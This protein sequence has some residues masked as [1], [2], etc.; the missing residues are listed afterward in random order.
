MWP[1]SGGGHAVWRRAVAPSGPCVTR[2]NSS[3]WSRTRA[4]SRSNAA[5]AAVRASWRS[6]RTRSGSSPLAAG[7]SPVSTQPQVRF[8]HRSRFQGERWTWRSTKRRRGPPAVSADTRGTGRSP[9]RSAHGRASGDRGAERT[10]ARDCDRRWSHMGRVL[11]SR[12]Q[13]PRHHPAFPPTHGEGHACDQLKRMAGRSTGGQRT[14]AARNDAGW[15]QRRRT[16]RDWR[17]R[18]RNPRRSRRSRRA[19]RRWRRG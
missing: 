10:A 17:I 11:A 13:A 7:V 18:R 5:P 19:R 6:A 15:G 2:A 4:A 16:G 3:K 8:R 1:G 14:V 12:G 9:S